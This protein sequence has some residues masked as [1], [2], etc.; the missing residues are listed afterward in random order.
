MV[1]YSSGIVVIFNLIVSL[2]RGDQVEIFLPSHGNIINSTKVSEN[3]TADVNIKHLE[4]KT[5]FYDN[6]YGEYQEFNYVIKLVVL[7]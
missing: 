1:K 4:S 7:I 3:T 2:T 5:F 6:N